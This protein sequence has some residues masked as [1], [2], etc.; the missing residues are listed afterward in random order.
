M[1]NNK[2]GHSFGGYLRAFGQN[3]LTLMSGSLSVLLLVATTFVSYWNK[4]GLFLLAAACVIFASFRIWLSQQEETARLRLRPYDKGIITDKLPEP[5]TAGSE[6]GSKKEQ[7]SRRQKMVFGILGLLI[8]VGS[9]VAKEIFR[10]TYKDSAEAINSTKAMFLLKNDTTQI[11]G[12]VWELANEPKPRRPGDVV[13]FTIRAPVPFDTNAFFDSVSGLIEKIPDSDELNS[14]LKSLRI[15]ND[16]FNKDSEKL[17]RVF[18][19]HVVFSDSHR[20]DLTFDN[21]C[22]DGQR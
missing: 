14:R 20:V 11:L 5:K 12:T 15:R 17:F 4:V 21:V 19:Q 10:D 7:S 13:R 8:I 1:A 16:Q 2:L 22:V 3:W 9:L 6:Q 18:N